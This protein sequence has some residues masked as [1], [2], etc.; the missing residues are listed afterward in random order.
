MTWQDV[1]GVRWTWRPR[2]A[3]RRTVATAVTVVVVGTLL[4]TVVWLCLWIGVGWTGILVAAALLFLWISE[5]W[6]I[7]V[8]PD[9]ALLWLKFLP[10]IWAWVHEDEA[11]PLQARPPAVE[12]EGRR[13]PSLSQERWPTRPW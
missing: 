3:V 7:V 8:E 1:L 10:G 5:K 4:G 9:N 13:N 2:R 6:W 11:P 12:T